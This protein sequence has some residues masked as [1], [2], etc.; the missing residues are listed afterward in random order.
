[1]PPPGCGPGREE[2][3]LERMAAA[4]PPRLPR[5][6]WAPNTDGPRGRLPRAVC[7]CGGGGREGAPGDVSVWV[8]SNANQGSFLGLATEAERCFVFSQAGE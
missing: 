8:S 3:F 5:V 6:E 7:V 1:M 4:V 2:A